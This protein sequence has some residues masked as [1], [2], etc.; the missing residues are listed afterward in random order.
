[1]TTGAHDMILIVDLPNDEAAAKLALSLGMLGN[2]RT[3][4]LKAFSEDSY[5]DIIG[6]V[7]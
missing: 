4:T 5:R 1:M 7:T 2:V 6:S 3:M